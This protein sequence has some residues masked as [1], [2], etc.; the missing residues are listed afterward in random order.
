[1]SIQWTE[2]LSVHVKIIDEQHKHFIGII[3]SLYKAYEDLKIK[4]ELASIV[5]ELVNYA[6]VHFSTEE[7]YFDLFKYEG[8]AEHIEQHQLMTKKLLDYKKRLETD[9]LNILAGEV[10]S[11]L[12]DWLVV[13]IEHYDQKYVECFTSHGLK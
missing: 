1:M 13:H 12:E 8:A 4:N 2:E 7:K 5:N 3:N 9:D 6:G 10:M 11:F